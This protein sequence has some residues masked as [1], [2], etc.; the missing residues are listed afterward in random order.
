MES[1]ALEHVKE[2]AVCEA[3]RRVLKGL[4]D[5]EESNAMAG[6]YGFVS[7]DDVKTVVKAQA[8]L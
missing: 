2:E 7:V 8:R 6:W 1:K 3:A 5:A 4:R